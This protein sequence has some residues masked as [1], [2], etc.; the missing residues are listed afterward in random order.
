MNCK[1]VLDNI[2]LYILDELTPEEIKYLKN[3]LKTCP[4]CQAE[5]E[6]YGDVMEMITNDSCKTLSEVEKL[7]L[8]NSIY[9]IYLSQSK[10]RT[11]H[12]NMFGYSLK[13]AA[14]IV[15]FFIGYF[16]STIT[17][18]LVQE[19]S[20]IAYYQNKMNKTEIYRAQS[21]M[22]RFTSD[23]LKIIAH[24]KSKFETD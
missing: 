24:G 2:P 10:N 23:G 4:A 21:S 1:Y 9:K 3:H 17:A 19:Q 8:E 15:I 22:L 6:S 7:K 14:V 18:D 11:S 16:S 5:F 13:A 12:K 20:R